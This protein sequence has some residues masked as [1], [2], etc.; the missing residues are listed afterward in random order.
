MFNALTPR[1]HEPQSGLNFCPF[2][3]YWHPAA[4]MVA[5]HVAV[6]HRLRLPEA[7]PMIRTAVEAQAAA[8]ERAKKIMAIKARKAARDKAR[9]GT[10]Q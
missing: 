1:D 3:E 6:Q 9:K 4:S 7:P 5:G 2:C 10:D 8:V